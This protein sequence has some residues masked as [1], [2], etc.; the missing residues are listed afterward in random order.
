MKD[1]ML[2]FQKNALQGVLT[3]PLCAEYKSEWR[4]IL[5]DKEKLVSFVLRQQSAPYF[6]HH[7]YMGKGLSKEYLLTEFKDYINGYTIQNADGVDGYSYGL[8]VGY[9]YDNAIVMD[10]DVAHI[11]YTDDATIVVPE[12]KCPV[13]YVSNKTNIHL[14]CEGYNSVKVY[15]FDEST[16]I[17]DDTD[18][19]CSV[20]TYCY[21]DVCKVYQ[22]KFCLS[23][24]IKTFRKE[25]RL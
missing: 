2:E 5:N 16:L 24:K 9:D 12:T 21:S 13:I 23:K 10:K 15:L 25:I 17:I 18:E 1:E 3:D 19:D 20:T 6:A 14:I 4:K 22:G 7:C 11:L 8:Y